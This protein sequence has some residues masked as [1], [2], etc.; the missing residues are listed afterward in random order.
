MN[1]YIRGWGKNLGKF[2]EHSRFHCQKRSPCE[3][4][5]LYGT[6]YSTIKLRYQKVN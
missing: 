1:N 5:I 2:P 4:L 6:P 3:T